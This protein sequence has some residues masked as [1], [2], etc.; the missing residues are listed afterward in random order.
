MAAITAGQS[1][2]DAG[3]MIVEKSQHL[4]AK[5]RVSG[6]GRCNVTHRASPPGEFSQNYPRG[7]RFLKK[8]LYEFGPEDTIEWFESRGVQLKTEADGRMFPISDSSSSIIECLEREASKLS[9]KI[10]TRTGVES[11]SLIEKAGNK[12]FE[13]HFSNE[14]IACFDRVLIA[15]GGYPKTQGFAWIANHGIKINDPAPSLFTFNSPGNEIIKLQGVSVPAARVKINTTKLE[16]TGPLLITHWGF[17]GPAV[18]KLS[19]WGARILQEKDYHYEISIQWNSNYDFS[20]IKEKLMQLR[21][22]K[23]R[24]SIASN[25]KFEIPSRLWA[26]LV[27]CSD[28]KEGQI[29]ADI[30]NK[31]IEKLALNLSSQVHGIK[32]KTTFKEEFVTCGGVDLS[33]IDHMTM[34]S[35]KVKGLYFAGEVIDVDGITGGFNF[36]NAWTTGFLAGRNMA[37]DF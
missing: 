4:L 20:E 13:V 15:T 32:G 30:S 12:M 9:I 6:G 1:N 29:W 19:A 23:S 18:L 36:Q 8:I 2:R 25:P 11:F 27:Q 26:Y 5:V 35:K 24:S 33:E 17:S 31:T 21:D 10:A 14:T 28:I 34:E 7:A 37:K 16:W 3:I 22:M